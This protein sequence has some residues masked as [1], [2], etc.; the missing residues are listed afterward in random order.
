[1]AEFTT[2]MRAPIPAS[3]GNQSSF[4]NLN[5]FFPNGFGPAGTRILATRHPG[6]TPVNQLPASRHLRDRGDE[7]TQPKKCKHAACNCMTTDGK[8]YCGDRCKDSKKIT[9]LVCQCNHPGCKAEA[10]KV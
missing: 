6:F 9:E 1:V 5:L 3:T 7:M 8:D 2:L 10:L 4:I